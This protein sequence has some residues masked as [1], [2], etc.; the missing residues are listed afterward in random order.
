MSMKNRLT[1]S[2][3]EPA[4][5]LNQLRHRGPNKQRYFLLLITQSQGTLAF[6]KRKIFRFPKYMEFIY[7]FC[8][9]RRWLFE[10]KS[11]A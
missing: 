10:R 5:C 11:V 8:V 1:P 2:G 3:I 4:Q 9:A 6:K 7:G